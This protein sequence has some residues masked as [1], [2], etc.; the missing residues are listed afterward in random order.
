MKLNTLLIALCGLAAGLGAG[1]AMA[2]WT[3]FQEAPYI[4]LDYSHFTYKNASQESSNNATFDAVRV[5]A[6]SQILPYLGLE[7][8]AGS[9]FDK[10]T[11][12]VPGATYDLNLNV[13]YGA[14]LRPQ[15]TYG[16]LTAYALGGYGYADIKY[17]TTGNSVISAASAQE[18]SGTSYG[19][20]AS[21]KVYNNI[22]VSAD[23]MHYL[24][25]LSAVSLGLV[26]HFPQ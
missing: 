24:S 15:I 17:N 18:N 7:V 23:Y 5:R 22:D 19:A 3:N 12:T 14:Y 25:G 11:I 6:G 9:G 26:Y 8:Q 1:N 10:G 16:R 4:G 2:D 21:V 13:F 20:G